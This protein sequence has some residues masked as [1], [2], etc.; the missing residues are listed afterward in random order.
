[1][2]LELHELPAVVIDE[3]NLVSGFLGRGKVMSFYVPFV[4]PSCDDEQERLVMAAECELSRDLPKM[5]CP[6]C[7][8]GMEVDGVAEHYLRILNLQ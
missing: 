2:A 7:K 8:Q 5:S 1:V 3:A 6:R 4:C